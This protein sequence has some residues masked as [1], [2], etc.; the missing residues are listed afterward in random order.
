MQVFDFNIHPKLKKGHFTKSFYFRNEILGNLCIICELHNC[1]SRDAKIIQ[2]I[3][4]Q[5]KESFYENDKIE[6]E[7]ALEISLQKVNEYLKNLSNKGN[8]RWLG[9]L[10]MVIVAIKDSK[11]YFA[12]NGDIKIILLRDKEYHDIAEHLEEQTSGT[13]FFSNI[14]K[15][16]LIKSDK[17]FILTK[18]LYEFFEIYL[19]QRILKIDSFQPKLMPRLLKE[20]KNELKTY[21][22][23]IFIVKPQKKNK[24]SL[25]L[26]KIKIP[27][28]IVLISILILIWIITYLLFN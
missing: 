25:N 17:V 19:A 11:I 14:A 3:S 16:E 7:T 5:V 4:N 26:P 22:G 21:S 6:T 8:V 1:V 28:E 10:G 15:G 23:I 20:A 2:E 24:K 12:K 18:E 9:N 13:T 27:K